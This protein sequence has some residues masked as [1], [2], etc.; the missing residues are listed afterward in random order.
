[1]TWEEETRARVKKGGVYKI[2]KIGMM[3]VIGR[4]NQFGD[5]GGL[6]V[7]VEIIVSWNKNYQVGETYCLNAE[8]M[9]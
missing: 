5:R 1:M 8:S 7:D 9:Y 4:I 6:F 3:K 2:D